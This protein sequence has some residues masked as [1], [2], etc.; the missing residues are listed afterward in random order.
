MKPVP[1]LRLDPLR[2]EDVDPLLA[3]EQANRAFFEIWINARSPDYYSREGI[4]RAI[5][6]AERESAE[7][8]GYQF[9][10]REHEVLVGRINLSQLRRTHWQS[11]SL[12]YRIGA[13]FNGR[14]I[15]KAAVQ[16]ITQRAFG[17]LA[18][19]RLEAHARPENLGS[20]GALKANGFE[21]FGH[22]K[23]SFQLHGQWFDMLY[24]EANAK[25]T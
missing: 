14:G 18:L 12:G 15:A 10:I 9:L 4:A 11:A 13:D 23:R 5:E 16:L 17:E 25:P 3:F 24:F 2:L 21:Q 22:S 6:A 8:R 20:I 19:M 1:D 7:D